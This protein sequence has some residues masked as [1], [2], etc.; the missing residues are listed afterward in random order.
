MDDQLFLLLSVTLS[1]LAPSAVAFLE[2]FQSHLNSTKKSSFKL[3]KLPWLAF[4]EVLKSMDHSDIFMLS[5]CSK[6]TLNILKFRKTKVNW[7]CYRDYQNELSVYSRQSF[8]TKDLVFF[9]RTIPNCHRSVGENRLKVVRLGGTNVQCLWEKFGINST[10]VF[11]KVFERVNFHSF[12]DYGI[13]CIDTN[14]AVVQQAVENYIHE[15]FTVKCIELE[16]TAK[17]YLKKHYRNISG[18]TDLTLSDVKIETKDLEEM[19]EMH[20]NLKSIRI[21]RYLSGPLSVDSRI[22]NIDNVL[23]YQYFRSAPFFWQ[24]FKGRYLAIGRGV[25]NEWDVFEFVRSWISGTKYPHLKLL[26]VTKEGRRLNFQWIL[27][28]LRASTKEWNRPPIHE[29]WSR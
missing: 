3:L 14:R 28:Q 1:F 22:F 23:L 25:Y 18:V 29:Y 5:L 8:D 6:N 19:L 2:Y 17:D 16:V 21:D 4:Q 20:P 27:N 11:K 15:I 10:S 7:L 26:V 12:K 13:E 9:A 24:N